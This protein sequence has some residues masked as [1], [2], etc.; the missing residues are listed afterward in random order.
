MAAATLPHSDLVTIQRALLPGQLRYA[1]CYG[2]VLPV[3]VTLPQYAEMLFYAMPYAT[4]RVMEATTSY[5]AAAA[6]R[7]CA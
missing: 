3:T 1:P 6:A 5:A 4:L 7:G 2:H